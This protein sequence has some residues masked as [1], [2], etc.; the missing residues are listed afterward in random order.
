MKHLLARHSINEDARV[1]GHP[2]FVSWE[3]EPLPIIIGFR[4]A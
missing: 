4:M 1:F 3:R 2:D